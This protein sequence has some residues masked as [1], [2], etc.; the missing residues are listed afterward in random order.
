MPATD[1]ATHDRPLVAID[2]GQTGI[3]LRYTTVDGADEI[4]VEGIDPASDAQRQIERILLRVSAHR[5]WRPAAVSIGLTGLVIAEARAGDLLH[6]W[7]VSGVSSVSIAHDSVTGYLSALELDPGVVIAAGTG[8][9]VLAVGPQGVAQVDAWGYLLGDAGGGYWLGRAGLDA[10]L[11]DQDGRGPATA[12][13]SDAAEMFGP[14]SHLTSHVQERPDRVR[15]V[16]AFARCVLRQAADGDATALRIADDGARE[17]ACSAIAALVRAGLG[18]TEPATVSWTGSLLSHSDLYRAR[19]GA[20][21]TLQLGSCRLV[22]PRSV[23]LDG[24]A[25]LQAVPDGHPLRDSIV[26]AALSARETVHG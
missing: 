17:L 24:C 15:A 20:Y 21:L 8:V 7:R 9:V 13:T 23:P 3:R 25:L 14:F 18:A 6:A 11:R 22:P 5:G 2:A 19:L 4:E 10:V 12:L 1:T 16:A 26:S